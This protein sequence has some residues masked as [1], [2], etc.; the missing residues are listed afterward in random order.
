MTTGKKT[1][2]QAEALYEEAMHL[3]E[4]RKYSEAIDKLTG[5]SLILPA[6]GAIWGV[7]G[8]TYR[9][10]DDLPNAIRCFQKSV[11]LLPRSE[12]ASL[13]LFHAKM[14]SGD[15]EGAFCEMK[16]FLA[17]STSEEYSRLL[18]EINDEV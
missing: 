9:D 15:V 11:E 10:A 14:Q 12:R 7:L 4:L 17:N 6:D 16:R 1:T 3:R 2:K 13:G 8:A 5:A 18:Q